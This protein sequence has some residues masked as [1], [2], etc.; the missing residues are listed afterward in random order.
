MSQTKCEGIFL[1]GILVSLVVSTGNIAKEVV[2]E[3][4]IGKT[5]RGRLHFPIEKYRN[6]YN[7][8]LLNIEAAIRESHKKKLNETPGNI[9]AATLEMFEKELNE[10]LSNI[11]EIAGQS[12]MYSTFDDDM[13]LIKAVDISIEANKKAM[14]NQLRHLIRFNGLPNFLHMYSCK[15]DGN[16][17]FIRLQ[18][19]YKS[20]LTPS[21]DDQISKQT[22]EQ[23]LKLYYKFALALSK[24]HAKNV[25]N[26]EIRFDNILIEK[27]S[28]LDLIIN[29]FFY[30]RDVEEDETY[31]SS[32][33]EDLFQFIHNIYEIQFGKSQFKNGKKIE[34][35]IKTQAIEEPIETKVIEE[36]IETKEIETT[37][38]TKEIEETSKNEVIKETIETEEKT[39]YSEDEFDFEEYGEL[40]QTNK[41]GPVSE[42]GEKSYKIFTDS[43]ISFF[44]EESDKTISRKFANA[45]KESL[46]MCQDYKEEV[47]P[48][49]EMSALRNGEMPAKLKDYVK[50]DKMKDFSHKNKPTMQTASKTFIGKDTL[51]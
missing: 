47:K 9:D 6:A 50:S 7:Q 10:T 2:E 33:K 13:T 39:I 5:C 14:N 29:N 4:Q 48:K 32:F 49:I 20:F 16:F 27:Y 24:V 42:C 51:I 45:L 23:L 43:M 19:Y 37:I 3:D 41:D 15:K 21:T 26:V 11:K 44:N 1:W 28:V 35:T 46:E 36:P 22:F 31:D 40:F 34:K 17:L 38:E 25:V 30:A 8:T 12:F 18:K